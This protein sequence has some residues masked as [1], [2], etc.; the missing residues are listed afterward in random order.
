MEPHNLPTVLWK[1]CPIRTSLGVLGRQWTLLVLRDVSFFRKVRFS[2][3]LHNNPGLSARLLSL[4]LKD[5][6][7]EGLIERVMNPQDHR[8]VWYNL[9]E[10]GSDVIPVLAALIQYGAKHRAREVFADKK[11]REFGTLFPQDQEYMLGGFLGYVRKAK[12]G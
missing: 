9:T 2:D 1:T 12:G 5:L 7:R 6:Q 4:R 3:I 10:K 8:V 11:P